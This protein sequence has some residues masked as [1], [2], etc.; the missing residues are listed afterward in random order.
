MLQH[1]SYLTQVL[2]LSLTFNCY[3]FVLAS[4]IQDLTRVNCCD[5]ISN[6]LLP[7]NDSLCDSD[8]PLVVLELGSNLNASTIRE[9]VDVYFECNIKANPWVYRVSWRHNVSTLLPLVCL[10]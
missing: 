2:G 10:T 6:T 5:V 9:G 4:P 8:V 7:R 1:Y 3:L